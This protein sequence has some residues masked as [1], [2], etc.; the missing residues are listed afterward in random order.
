MAFSW[1]TSH[2]QS[3]FYDDRFLP[4]VVTLSLVVVA[5]M[6]CYNGCR[7]R[8]GSSQGAKTSSTT[9]PF[10]QVYDAD[11]IV[12]G[13]GTAGASIA[14]S[15]ARQGRHVKLI[16]RE[17][18]MVDR[19]VGELMQPGGIRVLERLG[20]GECAKGQAT[21]SIDVNGYAVIRKV[22]SNEGHDEDDCGGSG[23]SKSEDLILTY[24]QR[25]PQT[26]LE[27]FGFNKEDPIQSPDDGLRPKGRSFH[28]HLFVDQLR[29]AA[30]KE[31]R[32]ECI[33]GSVR[34]LLTE[35]EIVDVKQHPLPGD[36]LPNEDAAGGVKYVD[37]ET[38]EERHVAA[39]LVITC[40]GMY[41][42]FRRH[43]HD[44]KAVTV[45]YFLGLV[46]KHE[47][48]QPPLPYPGRGHVVLADPVPILLYQISAT[49]TR[50]LVDIPRD[51]K[52]NQDMETYL[53]NHVCPQL[54][55]QAQ[56]CF[57]NACK[58]QEP[59]IMPNKFLPARPPLM[60]RATLL[61]D[62]WNMR[63]PL[64]GGGMT[65]ALKDVECLVNLLQDVDFS[66][67]AAVSGALEQYRKDRLYH[68]STINVLANA[69]YEVFSTPPQNKETRQRLQEACK[70]YMSLGSCFS[71][72]P[73]GLL[74]GLT[75]RPE[76]LSAHFFAVA[77]HATS[78][79]VRPIPT[80]TKL[81]QSY[82]LMHLACKIIMPL[83]D[84]ENATLLTWYPIKK[85]VD[86]IF[87]WSNMK[88]GQ[89]V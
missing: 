65:V 34:K 27:Y 14:T 11:V 89:I 72:G 28:N 69:L 64:T 6:L 75:P 80:W 66:D 48:D 17:W 59:V 24:P 41:S 73:V 43:L 39:P 84:V 12:V 2:F 19:I 87:P 8:K 10:N 74:S 18:G 45:S 60:K 21:G 82:D 4:S 67:E 77:L 33:K 20:L 61:G 44:G 42:T 32:V 81:R 26:F 38:G 1:Y 76:V 86:F 51:V 15:L 25:D 22:S 83:L 50:I 57:L 62:S 88:I 36:R 31:S 16:E 54:P 58:E 40:D 13:A 47:K 29:Q 3:L 53:R 63:H 79:A 52:E 23:K 71:A 5:W 85:T 56:E 55:I 49:E 68:A 30:R 35:K 46:L 37:N 7:S 9:E 70:L 78:H